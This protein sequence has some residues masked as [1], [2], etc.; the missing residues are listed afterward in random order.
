MKPWFILEL[1]YLFDFT[2]LT[3]LVLYPKKLQPFKL[4]PSFPTKKNEHIDK[5]NTFI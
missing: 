3:L 1:I 2:S 5:S 4:C